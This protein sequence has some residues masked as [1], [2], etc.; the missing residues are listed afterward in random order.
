[1]FHYFTCNPLDFFRNLHVDM[2]IHLWIILFLSTIGIGASFFGVSLTRFEGRFQNDEVTILW[3]VSDD[4]PV[5]EYILERKSRYE[6][7]FRELKRLNADGSRS[8]QY[9]DIDLYKDNVLSSEQVQY[10]LRI[11]EKDG[12]LTTSSILNVN[13]FPTAIRRTWGSIKAM[14][15]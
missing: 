14:F 2:K 6:N 4:M 10:R 7:G 8:Y 3:Q 15:Q 12:T 9:R 13:Y 5:R 1:M 11:L